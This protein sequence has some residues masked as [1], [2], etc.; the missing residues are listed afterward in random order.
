[1]NGRS[2]KRRQKKK[3]VETRLEQINATEYVFGHRQP[4]AA[5]SSLRRS[6]ESTPEHHQLAIRRDGNNKTP[7]DF[8][9]TPRNFDNED[10]DD[11]SQITMQADDFIQPLQQRR[12]QQHPPSRN[13]T[14]S[15]SSW[16]TGFTSLAEDFLS[17]KSIHYKNNNIGNPYTSTRQYNYDSSD[18]DDDDDS[19]DVF[20]SL[21]DD[22]DDEDDEVI[23]QPPHQRRRDPPGE[24]L[25][26]DYSDRQRMQPQAVQSLALLDKDDDDEEEALTTEPSGE[27]A[28]TLTTTNDDD[29]DASKLVE[30]TLT[31]IRNNI[32]NTKNLDMAI[33]SILQALRLYKDRSDAKGMVKA[34]KILA[35]LYINQEENELAL[36][37]YQDVQR[38]LERRALSSSDQ[39]HEETAC[40]LNLMG[41]V[42][43][44]QGD[45]YQA[46][47]KHQQALQLIKTE[48]DDD[49]NR[50][51]LSHP[52]VSQTLILIGNVY[53]MERNTQSSASAHPSDDYKKFIETGM[54]D[55]IARA[56][57]AGGSYKMALSFLEEKLQLVKHAHAHDEMM[58]DFPDET[59]AQLYF[60]LGSVSC[61]SGLY[62]EAIDY[63]EQAL[64]IQIRLGCTEADVA[65]VKVL[66][67]TVQSNLG[68][69]R[70]SLILLEEAHA[71]F[72]RVFGHGTDMVADVLREIGIVKSALW[73]HDDALANLED[74]LAIQVKL[75]GEND[76]EVCK[77]KLEICTIEMNRGGCNSNLI[78]ARVKEILLLQQAALGAQQHP[79]VA[80]TLLVL[81]K[82]Y[83][84]RS[85]SL[86]TSSKAMRAFQESF[87]MRER[88][89]GQNHP[90]QAETRHQMARLSL[91]RERF[92][93]ALETCK[94]VLTIRKESL[95]ERHVHV[96]STLCLMGCAYAGMG[97]F[98]DSQSCLEEA[99]SI[100]MEAVGENHPNVGEIHVGLGTLWLRKCD[101][102]PA[103][104]SFEK[105][106]EIYSI[107]QVPPE[108]L[109]VR[110]AQKLLER[111]DRD[112]MLCV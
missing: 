109:L 68:H 104:R 39:Q 2:N 91:R 3:K 5:S 4:A 88:F 102:M 42:H 56:H 84:L 61:K 106:L 107:S 83:M 77:T 44:R 95:F 71:V 59:R 64:E 21:V 36:S 98:M 26:A 73:H 53:H 75:Y 8:V 17:A 110:D 48:C 105:G 30:L 41:T 99:L 58:N 81:G 46:M 35:E 90:M 15:W 100:A 57:E 76:L 38:I 14:T 13:N 22:N 89:L 93:H 101:F 97:K 9:K 40:I 112:E 67:G 31:R 12:R 6:L 54:L 69:Y 55:V 20:E 37:C 43:A 25:A 50:D 108:H 45:F 72:E 11:L 85:S 29:N 49:D 79:I 18:E 78:S 94:S 7:I 23:K 32:N 65:S 80:D 92:Q 47:E 34:L 86:S 87:G 52:I 16:T 66:I 33:D 96:A 70:K 1:M 19:G 27:T 82:V 10:D 103:R 62:L 111:V 74:A 60:H 63:Y 28:I 51:C 24:Q